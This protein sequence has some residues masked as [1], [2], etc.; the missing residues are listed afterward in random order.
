[1]PL[2]SRYLDAKR[3]VNLRSRTKEGAIRELA[4]AL[5]GVLE[6]AEPADVIRAIHERDKI[7]SSWVGPGIAIPHAHLPGCKGIAMSVGRSRR[8]VSWDSSDGNPVNLVLLIIG[9]DDEPDLH[10]LLLAEIARALR[11]RALTHLMLTARTSTEVYRLLITHGYGETEGKQVSS[12]RVRLSRLLFAHALSVAEEVKATAV[13][14]HGDA[15]GNLHFMEDIPAQVPLILVTSNKADIPGEKTQ[16][17]HVV[18]VPFP[19]HHR[20]NQVELGLLFAVSQ[21]LLARGDTVVSLSG[22]PNSG[23]LDTLLVIDVGREFPTVFSKSATM[24]LGDVEP[25][26]LEK[27]LQIASDISREGREGRPIGTAFV[28]GDYERVL[29]YCRQIVINPFRGY[30]EQE[31]NVLDP[32]IGETVKEFSTIDGAFIVR[33]DG[34]IM[35]AG[36]FLRPDRSA[37]NLPS[38]LGARHAAAAALTAITTSLAVVVSQSTGTVSLFK[39]GGLVMGLE[40]SGMRTGGEC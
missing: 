5:A 19:T 15:V 26:V 1:M 2:L 7:V 8:G 30:S 34:V 10:V 3:I 40:K 24:P 31:K 36:T 11:D 18:Q 13:V 37:V 12:G 25:Q 9:G 39:G 33:G 32:S 35:S 29:Q 23:S 27:V 14:L 22:V 20:S 17:S 28:V 16:I 38:G 21:G 4:N 6:N